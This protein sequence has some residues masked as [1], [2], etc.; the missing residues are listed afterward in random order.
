M[1]T[2]QEADS[3]SLGCIHSEFLWNCNTFMP[4]VKGTVY[5][6]PVKGT[7]R[8]RKHEGGVWEMRWCGAQVKDLH[9]GPG[10]WRAACWKPQLPDCGVKT[11]FL[12]TLKNG[13]S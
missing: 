2:S 12:T 4:L 6:V 7:G 10:P 11:P 13:S 5:E 1:F 3:L 9:T 8:G